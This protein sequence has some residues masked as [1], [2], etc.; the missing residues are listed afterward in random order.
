VVLALVFGLPMA[1]VLLA[2]LPVLLPV[3]IGFAAL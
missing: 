1:A 3:L 2:Q